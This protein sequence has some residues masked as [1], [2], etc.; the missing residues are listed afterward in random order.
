MMEHDEAARILCIEQARSRSD[1]CCFRSS[2]CC[3]ASTDAREAIF[4]ACTNDPQPRRAATSRRGGNCAYKVPEASVAALTS[5]RTPILSH[6]N[7]V[8]RCRHSLLW[9]QTRTAELR[10]RSSNCSL[11]YL[12]REVRARAGGA[13]SAASQ[14]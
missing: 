5:L 11:A 13:P 8:S 2:E 1:R 10:T 3:L 14:Q 12:E 9:V 7:V 4:G 6:A